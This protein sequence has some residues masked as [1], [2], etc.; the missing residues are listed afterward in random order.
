MEEESV[1]SSTEDDDEPPPVM[2]RQS[3]SYQQ[4]L[5]SLNTQMG[6]LGVQV[7][8]MDARLTSHIVSNTQW[9]QQAQQRLKSIDTNMQLQQAQLM[10]YF[11]HQGFYPPQPPQ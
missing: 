8:G 7:G 5:D 3:V 4:Q 6:H 1:C 11:A 9:Q 2:P 10:A